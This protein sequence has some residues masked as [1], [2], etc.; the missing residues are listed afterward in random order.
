MVPGMND[1]AIVWCRLHLEFSTKEA[2]E[3]VH[4]SVSLDNEGYLRTWLE[5]NAIVAEMEAQSLY[6]LLHTL[7]DFL[8]CA[9]VADRVIAKKP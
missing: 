8:A 1:S 5:G 4:G 3:K 2:A 9:G 7:D 6:S